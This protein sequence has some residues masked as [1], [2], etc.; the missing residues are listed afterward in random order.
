MSRRPTPSGPALR[1]PIRW[2]LSSKP[3]GDTRRLARLDAA[4]EIRFARA[5]AR[6]APFVRRALDTGSHANR[7]LAWEPKDGLILEPWRPARRRWIR[8]A[9]RLATD[10][11]WVAVTDVRDCYPSITAAAVA[12]RLQALGAPPA[13]ADEIGSWL[14]TFAGEGVDGLPIGPLASAVLADAVL[15]RGDEAIRVTGVEHLRWVD[16]VVI[17]APDRRAGVRSLDALRESL[18]LVGLELHDGKTKT[19]SDPAAVSAHLRSRRNSPGAHPRC[20]NRPR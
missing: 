18:S 10:A 14:K 20:D 16:D 12:A 15:S 6:A 7:V 19:F 9:S 5:V 3:D 4:D 11:R 17:F 1:R 2:E 8:Q 13:T